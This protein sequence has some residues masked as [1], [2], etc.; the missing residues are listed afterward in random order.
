VSRSPSAAKTT[1]VETMKLGSRT[2]CT[3]VPATGRAACAGRTDHVLD[4]H[5]HIGRA[6]V[7]QALGQLACGAARASAFPALEKSITSHAPRYRA[8]SVAARSRI[9]AVSEKLPAATTPT[10]RVVCSGVDLVVVV[11]PRAR[12]NRRRRSRLARSPR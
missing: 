10:P 6:H 1:S 8:A 12:S 4:G 3:C 11:R 5:G 9:A 2:E 7:A